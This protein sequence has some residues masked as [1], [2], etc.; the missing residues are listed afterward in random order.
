MYSDAFSAEIADDPAF[1]KDADLKADMDAEM[2][3]AKHVPWFKQAYKKY[4]KGK[5]FADQL[6]GREKYAPLT[7]GKRD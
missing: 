6:P 2:R 1:Y 3:E 5:R 4:A 7:L